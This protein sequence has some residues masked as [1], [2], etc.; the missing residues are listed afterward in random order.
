MSASART[1]V[2]IPGFPALSIGPGMFDHYATMA[3]MNA[4]YAR[5][6][7]IIPQWHE[8]GRTRGSVAVAWAQRAHEIRG[9]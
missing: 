4:E 9:F 6:R 5:L 8:D 2:V 1:T 7:R 3:E